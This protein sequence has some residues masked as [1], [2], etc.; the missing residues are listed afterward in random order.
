MED[1]YSV[2]F[3][4]YVKLPAAVAQWQNTCLIILNSRGQ[5]QL[6]PL[7]SNGQCKGEPWVLYS[8]HNPQMVGLNPAHWF[9][10]EQPKK[11]KPFQILILIFYCVKHF[12]KQS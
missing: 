12:F 7:A 11:V 1:T 8:I 10:R 9:G 4:S 3:K 5:I 6:P 2:T